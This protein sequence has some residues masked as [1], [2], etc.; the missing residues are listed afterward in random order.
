LRGLRLLGRSQY[1]GEGGERVAAHT[2]Q[3][4]IGEQVQCTDAGAGAILGADRREGATFGAD[5]VVPFPVV[6][7]RLDR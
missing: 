4:F 2:G 6:V 1:G 5:G 7:V 3:P